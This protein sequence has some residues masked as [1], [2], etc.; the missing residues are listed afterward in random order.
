MK[1]CQRALLIAVRNKDR[2]GRRMAG[3]K[4][5]EWAFRRGYVNRRQTGDME[6]TKEGMEVLGDK[7]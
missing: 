2:I 3:P 6:L 7:A 1:A 5:L 4:V